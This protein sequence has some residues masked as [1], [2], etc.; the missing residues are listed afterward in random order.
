MSFML[1]SFLHDFY[2]ALSAVESKPNYTL[3]RGE[4]GIKKP[5]LTHN[6]KIGFSY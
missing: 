2:T 1:F 6:V 4:M 5:R 3:G